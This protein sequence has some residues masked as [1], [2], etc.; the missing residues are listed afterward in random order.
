[1]QN[2]ECGTKRVRSAE[3]GTRRRAVIILL[4]TALLAVPA[5]SCGYHLSG[6][7]SLIPEG[8]RTIAVPALI[9][10]TF[11][12]FVDVEVTAAVVNEFIADG[13]LKVV[14]VDRA[15]VVLYGTIMKFQLTALSYTANAFAQQYQVRLVLD[16]R[17]E[18]R[19][20]KQILWQENG[21]ESVFISD[22]PVTVGDISATKAAKEGA[23]RKASQDIAWTLRSRV[24]EGF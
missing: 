18:D 2:A 24:L 10:K 4:L 6:R 8:A 20:T 22:Y 14:D 23:I 7:G 19:R 1:M 9:N 17:L 13:R 12:P 16:A 3:R 15:D 5:S 21:I 11:E